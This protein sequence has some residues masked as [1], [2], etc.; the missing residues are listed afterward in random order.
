MIVNHIALTAALGCEG[1]DAEACTNRSCLAIAPKFAMHNVLR[2]LLSESEPLIR[3]P[4]L[5]IGTRCSLFCYP[6]LIPAG[7]NFSLE[8]AAF[9]Y[10]ET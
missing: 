1:S 3:G 7:L 2:T 8:S 9:G 5:S 10:I 4:S 6:I